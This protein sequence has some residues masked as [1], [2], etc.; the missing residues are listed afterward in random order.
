MNL[1]TAAERLGI[2]LKKVASTKGGEYAGSCP[3]CGGVDRFRVW[4]E[5]KGGEGSFWCRRCNKGSDLVQFFKEFCNYT[6]PDAFKAA[7]RINQS[8]PKKPPLKNGFVPKVFEAPGETWRKK[9]HKLVADCHKRLLTMDPILKCLND[10]GLDILA[11][12]K[13]NLGWFPGENNKNSMF[14]P[15]SSWGLPPMENETGKPKM[16]WIPRGIVIPCFKNGTIYRIRIRRPDEDL[17]YKKDVRYYVIPGSGMD[18]MGINSDRQAFV[19][20]ESEL[21]AMLTARKAGSLVGS[22]AVGSAQAKPGSSI[23]PYLKKALKIL[24]SLDWDAAGKESWKWWKKT[25]SNAKL[26]PVP[27]GKDPGEAFAKGIDIKEWIAVGLPPAL[28]TE[29]SYTHK[30]PQGLCPPEDYYPIQELEFFLK[31]L[32]IEIVATP[33][34][35]EVIFSPGLRNKEIK[36]RVLK[37]FHDDEVFYYLK[38]MHPESVIHGGN[39]NLKK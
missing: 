25:F 10:R 30:I 35:H 6:W 4:P 27:V 39:F 37:A 33:D 17:Q 1:L 26:W 18:G 7:G 22:V 19:I 32:P 13:F 15:R 2:T 11:V 16:L 24:V 20:V 34:R 36:K 9:A 31:R 14:R 5:D 12:K 28:T 23:Y 3:G 29:M 8:K 21:D 38:L